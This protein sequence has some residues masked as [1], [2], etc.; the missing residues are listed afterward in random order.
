[1]KLQ[2]LSL[3]AVA[4]LATTA[5]PSASAQSNQIPE[6]RR[7]L[8]L[9]SQSTFGVAAVN[10]ILNSYGRT[11]RRN[12]KQ[13]ALLLRV[14]NARLNRFVRPAQ[15]QEVALRLSQITSSAF[16]VGR[17]TADSPLYLQTFPFIA[18]TL[19]V[20]QRTPSILNQIVEVAAFAN[21][22]AGG[23]SSIDGPVADAIS[24]QSGAVPPPVS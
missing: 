9:I 18:N 19:P 24:G 1:M 14:A 22:A 3:L 5:L 6:L 4:A 17:I 2:T 20:N 10:A 15:R 7:Q 11:A 23:D 21:Q 13:A 16:I 8:G 12:P